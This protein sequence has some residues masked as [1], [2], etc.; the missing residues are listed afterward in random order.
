ITPGE[1]ACMLVEPMQGEGGYY[2]ASP[3]FLSALRSIC[4]EHGI[5]LIA[6]EVQTGFGRTGEWFGS[7]TLGLRPDIVVYG[8][9]IA[10]G[11]PLSAVGSSK[12]LFSQWPAGSHGTTYG[13]NPISCAASA[14][15]ID[16]LTEVLPGVAARS[17]HSFARF[18]EM[19]KTHSVIGDIRGL[20][21]MIGVELVDE[22]LDADPAAIGHVKSVG[23]EEGLFILDCGPKENV[24]RF[25]PPLNVSMEDLDRGLDIIDRA[26]SSYE[27]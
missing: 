12:E 11:F 6:D 22:N 9:G 14:A 17:E 10:N 16:G 18:A 19:K 2:P 7:H 13:G 20:G 4:D 25:L 5:L 8:K 3:A 23:L 27:A 15:T 21:L 24:I 26:L 1:V